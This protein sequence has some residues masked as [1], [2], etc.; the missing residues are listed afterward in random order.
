M[1]DKER[2]NKLEK[3]LKNLK[4]NGI[5]IF[6]LDKFSYFSI[7]SLGEEDGSNLGEQICAGFSLREAIDNI[8]IEEGQDAV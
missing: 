1:S 8:K 6:P 7:D 4:S 3:L 2:I 5:A